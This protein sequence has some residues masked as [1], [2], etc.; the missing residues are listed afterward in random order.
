[1]AVI[2][3]CRVDFAAAGLDYR[4]VIVAGVA[5]ARF[6]RATDPNPNRL[7]TAVATSRVIPEL[8]YSIQRLSGDDVVVLLAKPLLAYSAGYCLR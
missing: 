6:C 1:M 4:L 3:G 2:A 8:F 7:A 5:S